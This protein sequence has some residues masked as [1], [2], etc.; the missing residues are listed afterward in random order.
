VGGVRW[1]Y[2]RSLE[3]FARSGG[4]VVLRHSYAGTFDPAVPGSGC[5]TQRN[6]DDRGRAQ[7]ERIGEAFRGNG[8]AVGTVLSSPRCRCLDTARL[9]FGR[10][11]PWDPLQGALRDEDRRRR[12]V[13]EIK[14]VIAAHGDG[15]PLVL[16]TH[17][18]VVQD[19]TAQR[20][21]GRVRGAAADG[22][23]QPH[24]CSQLYLERC[25]YSVCQ[26]R[27]GC[28][29]RPE[30]RGV[31]EAPGAPHVL[32]YGRVSGVAAVPRVCENGPWLTGECP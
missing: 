32:R 8:I 9:A 2:R 26:G 14:K 13:A 16:V 6:L 7:A 12:E 29:G 19:L 28:A 18:S 20:A 5:S 31:W 4:V 25:E 23:R 11:Q 10:A 1:N 22:R 3:G 30:R 24:G 15:P 27:P 21:D 17:G